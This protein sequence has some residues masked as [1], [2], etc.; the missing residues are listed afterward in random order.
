[1]EWLQGKNVVVGITGGIAAYKSCE[2]VRSLMRDGAEVRCVMTAS[3]ER[4]ITPL[5]LQTLSGN[6]VASNL[7]D[8]SSES[9][10][11]H[12]KIADEADVVVVAPASASFIGKIASGIA[13]SLLATVITATK[14]PVIVCPAMNS[15]MYSNSIV[16]GNIDKLRRHGFIIVEPSEGELACGW[17]GRGRLAETDVIALEVQKA[18][19]PQDY[20]GENI[21]VSAGAT[22]E[23]IDPVRF[24]SNPSTGK[25]GYSIALAAWLRGAHVTMVSGHSSLSD[26]HGVEV[27]RV[28][29]CEE[30]Y[31][32]IHERFDLADILIKS[33]AVSDYSPSEKSEQKIKKSKKQLSIPLKRTR[34]ILKSLGRDKKDKILVGFA[35]ETENIFENSQKKLEEKNLD[36][37]VA[38]DITIPQAGF[39]EDTNIAWLVDRE[40]A[41]EL[42]LMSKF[43]LAN[44]ILD[45]VKKIK[46]K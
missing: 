37:I 17:T 1:M 28:K 22:R 33:A 10:I 42:P 16:Q 20:A 35:A 26:P 3:A 21:L 36:L 31:K 46:K 8:L 19:T 11:G 13:D 45:R 43:E 24:I 34:D 15:N 39:A 23:H 29:D 2:L 38:N 9:E 40:K 18:L 14:A 44:S 41:E 5:T 30:M 7:F 25:M 27:V 32:E 6:K 12:I 4:F